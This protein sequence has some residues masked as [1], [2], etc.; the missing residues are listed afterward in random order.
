MQA[1]DVVFMKPGGIIGRLVA[2][3]DGSPYSHVAIAVSETHIAEAQGHTRSRVWPLY[4]RD[5]MV[6][7]LPLTEEQRAAIPVIAINHTGRWYDWRLIAY[8]FMNR[9]LRLDTKAI[10]NSQNNLIC[11]ELVA[12]VLHTAGYIPAVELK[13]KNVSPS[14]LYLILSAVHGEVTRTTI[15]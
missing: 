12:S 4:E 13:N 5:N 6:L 7:S 8:Y 1:G 10:W 3:F 9:V 15:T 14:E 11:S 2:K